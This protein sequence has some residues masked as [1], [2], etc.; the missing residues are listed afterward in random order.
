MKV[1][2]RPAWGGNGACLVSGPA[3]DWQRTLNFRPLTMSLLYR[4]ND[5][6]RGKRG[7]EA[8]RGLG[9]HLAGFGRWPKLRNSSIREPWA[10][11]PSPCRGTRPP[12][13]QLLSSYLHKKNSQTVNRRDCRHIWMNVLPVASNTN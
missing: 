6:R 1:A 8:R 4:H 13:G 10:A 12:A 2:A 3:K 5:K 11:T 9:T 7:Q